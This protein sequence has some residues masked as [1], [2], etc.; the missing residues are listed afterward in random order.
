MLLHVEPEVENVFC[1][2]ALQKETVQFVISDD[3]K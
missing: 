1:T 2:F 3:T